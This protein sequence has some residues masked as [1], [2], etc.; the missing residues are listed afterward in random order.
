MEPTKLVSYSPFHRRH[1]STLEPHA[2]F[3]GNKPP[4]LCQSKLDWSNKDWDSNKAKAREQNTSLSFDIPKPET[5]KLTSDSVDTLTFQNLT[6]K[7]NRLDE[8]APEV[9]TTLVPPPEPGAIGTTLKEDGIT[10][11]EDEGLM[12]QELRL[13]KEEETYAIYIG[14]LSPKDSDTDMEMDESKYPFYS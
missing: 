12:E 8:K 9:L 11:A 2:H 14:N 10:K 6:I 5:D 3:V 4:I 1:V 13:Q 7:M